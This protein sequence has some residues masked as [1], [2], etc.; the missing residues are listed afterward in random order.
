MGCLIADAP[1]TVDEMGGVGM[2]GDK[3]SRVRVSALSALP[4][5]GLAEEA[6]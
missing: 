5:H 2:S 6:T 3:D 1:K 4:E